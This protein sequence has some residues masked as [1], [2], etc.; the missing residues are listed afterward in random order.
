[1]IPIDLQAE[2]ALELRGITKRFFSTTALDDVDFAVQAGEI[3]ALLGENGAGK[4]TLIKIVTGALTP[5]SGEICVRGRSTILGKPR[6]ATAAGITSLPQEVVAVPHLSVGRNVLLG[7]EARCAAIDRLSATETER[8]QQALT[9]VGATFSP[10]VQARHL[11][12]ADLRLTQIARTLVQVGDIIVMDEPTAVLSEPEAERLL[13]HLLSFRSHGKAIIYVTHRLSEVMQIADRATI[14]RDGRRVGQLERD[15]FDRARIVALM[16]KSDGSRNAAAAHLP[17]LYE[18][19]GSAR[20]LEIAN[21]T[22]SQFRGV[23]F[24]AD[25]GQIVGIAGIQG[26]GHADL[27]RVLAGVEPWSA[28]SVMIFGRPLRSGSLASA[29]GEGL[30]LV[31]ADR[32]NSAILPRLSVQENIAVNCRVRRACR[33]FGFRSLAQERT[34]ARQHI[35]RMSIDPPRYQTPAREL[36][37]GNQQKVALARALEG[38]AKVLLLD[39]PTQGVDVRSKSEIHDLLRNEAKRGRTMVIASSEFEE[40]LSIADVIHVMRLGRLQ[41]TLV[42]NERDYRALLHWALP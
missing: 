20:P 41:K 27:L 21:L 38:N 22:A 16:A 12:T 32:R 36:S 18:E 30:M 34:M 31:P 6:D 2:P 25:H 33:R 37:G 19:A 11:S 24:A 17:A 40:L 39:E 3:H 42:A 9:R 15:T 26:S 35:R 4:S 1:M 13:Q 29:F 28:G 10:T 8:V 23:S 7:L 5:D 14:L